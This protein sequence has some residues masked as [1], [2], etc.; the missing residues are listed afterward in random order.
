[1]IYDEGKLIFTSLED[2]IG[3]VLN[4]KDI[5]KKMQ[6][7]GSTNWRQSEWPGFYLEEVSRTK[8]IETIGGSK[9]RKYGNVEMDYQREFIWDIKT[10]ST[11]DKNMKNISE[12]ILNDS[13]AI[14]GVQNDFGAAGFIIYFLRP[15]WDLDG[16]FKNW[17]NKE[18]GE[19]SKYSIERVARNAPSRIRKKGGKIVGLKVI[20]LTK[21]DIENGKRDGWIKGFQN[22]M[23][24]SNG[25]PRRSKVSVVIDK[26][27][28]EC[29][30]S[31][32]NEINGMDRLE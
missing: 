18:K 20:M 26:I 27:P 7:Y 29:I 24:N 9:G 22:G 12:C 25:S 21:K 13:E 8:L 10:H 28:S 11:I 3:I 6:Q 19:I 16:E 5:V 23:R 30:V 1:M 32:A 17:H 15:D 31:E 4:G 14:E 2:K